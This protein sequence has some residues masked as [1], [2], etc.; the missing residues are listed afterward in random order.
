MADEHDEN[1]RRNMTEE[2]VFV[3]RFEKEDFIK[4]ADKFSDMKRVKMMV[5][6][7]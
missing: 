7:Y 1:E 5:R 6:R 3:V 2:K 4:F